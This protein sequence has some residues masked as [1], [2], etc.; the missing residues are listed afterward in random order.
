MWSYPFPTSKLLLHQ[1]LLNPCVFSHIHCNNTHTQTIKHTS[2][3]YRITTMNVLFYQTT[4]F[5]NC[6]ITLIIYV[7]APKFARWWCVISKTK[8]D[9]PTSPIDSRS[10]QCR[11]W[12]IFEP[13][14]CLNYL[15]NSLL[16]QRV[17][18]QEVS[19]V[20]SNHVSRSMWTTKWLKTFTHLC[21]NYPNCLPSLISWSALAE[22]LQPS[23]TNH[24]SYDQHLP[25]S[26]SSQM[27]SL[28]QVTTGSP[29]WWYPFG[30][31]RWHRMT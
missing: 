16:W 20:T 3:I 7:H 9:L 24:N 29:T 12:S 5:T 28:V 6:L 26:R 8:F 15:M 31:L 17:R 11:H 18:G 14:C 19:G 22:R 13:L 23:L 1:L 10:P 25:R 30:D 4:L 27:Q 2:W 21:H